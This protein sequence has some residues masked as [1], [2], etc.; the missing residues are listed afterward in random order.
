MGSRLKGTC[1][2]KSTNIILDGTT[3]LG[4]GIVFFFSVG[5][6]GGKLRQFGRKLRQIWA[7]GVKAI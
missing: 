6:S 4:G 2:R 3:W 7:A 5:L 1:G